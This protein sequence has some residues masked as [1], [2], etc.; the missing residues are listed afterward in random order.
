M[1]DMGMSFLIGKPVTQLYSVPDWLETPNERKPRK[2]LFLSEPSCNSTFD[3]TQCRTRG[4]FGDNV[5]S[6]Y[7]KFRL[8][9][10]PPPPLPLPLP[11]H[12]GGGAEGIKILILT[13]LDCWKRHF[14]EQNYIENYFYLL[15]STKTTKT[16]SQKS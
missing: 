15:K 5:Y 3:T 13:T 10:L 7:C 2:F 4:I 16:T 12:G 9:T 11:H 1:R 8:M 6:C 14:R